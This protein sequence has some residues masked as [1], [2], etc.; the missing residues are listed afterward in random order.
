[1]VGH[2]GPMMGEA[3]GCWILKKMPVGQT[4]STRPA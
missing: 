1:M 2:Y 4:Q 3:G